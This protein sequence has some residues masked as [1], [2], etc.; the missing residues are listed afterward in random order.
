MGTDCTRADFQESR[1][2]SPFCLDGIIEHCDSLF[3]EGKEKQ[4]HTAA[5][6]GTDEF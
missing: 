5:A 2:F 3:D 4:G 1:L 6:R